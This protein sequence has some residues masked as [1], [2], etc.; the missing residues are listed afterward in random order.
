MTMQQP[1][2]MLPGQQPLP[3][4][5]CEQGR[6]PVPALRLMASHELPLLFSRPCPH[7]V[8]LPLTA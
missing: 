5:R 3:A 8:P 7:L 2:V 1:P 4:T 6:A